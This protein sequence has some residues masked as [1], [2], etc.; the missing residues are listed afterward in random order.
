MADWNF[1]SKAEMKLDEQNRFS[2]PSAYRKDLERFGEKSL[3]AIPAEDPDDDL[4]RTV[5]YV[6]LLPH[7]VLKARKATIKEGIDTGTASGRRKLKQLQ[8]Q[9]AIMDR[10]SW[11]TN[12]RIRIS[13]EVMALGGLPRSPEKGKDRKDKAVTVIVNGSDEVIQV[14]EPKEYRAWMGGTEDLAEMPIK[15]DA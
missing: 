12:G 9:Y 4:G 15:N 8:R 10:V 11:D 2:L 13:D 1:Y 5:K 3:A 6:M 7:D 14:W